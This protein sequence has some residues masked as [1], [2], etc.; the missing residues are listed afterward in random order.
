MG[1]FAKQILVLLISLTVLLSMCSGLRFKTH[2]VKECIRND[3]GLGIDL[4][5]HCRSDDDDLG[6]MISFTEES[7]LLVSSQ[8]FLGRRTSIAVLAGKMLRNRLIFTKMR[9]ITVVAK[10]VRGEL[11]S[12]I[13]VSQLLTVLLVLKRVMIGTANF[14]CDLLLLL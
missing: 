8:I 2:E 9:G 10:I 12:I 14:I 13:Y 4:T 3:I 5:V 11:Q 1:Y 7:T 6:Y